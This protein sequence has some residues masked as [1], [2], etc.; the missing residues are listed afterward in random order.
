MIR[1]ISQVI[2][3]NSLPACVFGLRV[4]LR[5]RRI[6]AKMAI[7]PSSL[8]MTTGHGPNLIILLNNNLK[9]AAGRNPAATLASNR[10]PPESF[11]TTPCKKG[12]NVQFS[13]SAAYPTPCPCCSQASLDAFPDQLGLKFSQSG[14][15]SEYKL[16]VGRCC[17]DLSAGAGL[18]P[19]AGIALVQIIGDVSRMLQ[20]FS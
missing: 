12:G 17:I 2:S 5:R 18:H 11:S 14:K 20:I 1:A 13:G 10:R 16:T 8:A 3:S 15:D 7:P 6:T 19:K 4:W 9:I